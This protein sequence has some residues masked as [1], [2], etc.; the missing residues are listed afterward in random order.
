[1]TFETLWERLK[2]NA[3][4]K[5]PDHLRRLGFTRDERVD[6]QQRALTRL[7]VHVKEHTPYYQESLK[8]INV[9]NFKLA[10]MGMLPVTTKQDTLLHWNSFVSDG[11]LTKV[12]AEQHL[13]A[14]RDDPTTNPFYNEKYF[15]FATGGSSGTRGLFVWSD[16]DFAD[17]ICCFHRTMIRDNQRLGKSCGK[18]SVVV[19]PSWLHMSQAVNVFNYDPSTR[20]QYISADLPAKEMVERLE[21][22]HPD[23][24]MGFTTLIAELA[25][26]ATRGRLNIRPNRVCTHS[27]PLLD[28]DRQVIREAWQVEVNNLW[29]STEVG[30]MGF[31]DDQHLGL[32]IAEDC[33]LIEMVDE[34]LQPV[35][36]P[37]EA[38]NLLATSLI[39][40][41]FPLIRYVLDDA[42]PIEESED[43]GFRLAKQITGRADRWFVY[44]D[45]VKVHPIAFRH[46]LG[47]EKNIQEYQVKQTK[48]GAE[49]T[50]VTGGEVS[51]T[52]VEQALKQELV[53]AGL[54]QPEVVLRR[55]TRL[56]RH[57]ETG[58]R[59]RFIPLGK[60]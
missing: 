11:V 27:E 38:K 4:N 33:C 50:L 39:N 2:Q 15:I 8:E 44:P 47:Q 6:Y 31:E 32:W 9:E 54:V 60:R 42:V 57:A 13:Q 16:D 14:L 19:S 58:K 10:D 40:H 1:M 48:R 3:R 35:S 43:R 21:D 25:H 17:V 52:A 24:L 26:L 45:N 56:E 23:L 46:V 36:Q 34:D 12:Q 51:L 22:F 49:V 53:Q 29:G 41:T 5:M 20:V 18:I 55:V 30:V 59:K 37:Q 7:L 28:D